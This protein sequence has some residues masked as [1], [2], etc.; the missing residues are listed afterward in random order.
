MKC[1]D[2]DDFIVLKKFLL[3]AKIIPLGSFCN[4]QIS[5]FFLVSILT[6]QGGNNLIFVA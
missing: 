6:L 2:L 1:V 4:G 5:D 3:E